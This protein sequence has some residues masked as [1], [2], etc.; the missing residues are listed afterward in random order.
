MKR[1]ANGEGTIKH[2]KDGRWEIQVVL[3]DGS[4][5]SLFGKTQ[6]EALDELGALR[7]SQE[8]GISHPN[9][10]KKV[11]TYLMTWI[12]YEQ[13]ARVH[14]DSIAKLPLAKLGPQHIE[15]LYADRLKAGSA[16]MTVRHLHALLHK[17][18]DQ[19]EKW[20]LVA[21]NA[22]ALVSPPTAAHQEMKTL[23]EAQS[24]TFLEAVAGER[25]EALHVLA[26]S[27]GMR[28]GEILALRWSD[29][30][31]DRASAQIQR[32]IQFVTG[33]YIFTPPKTAKSRRKVELTQTA[34]AALRRQR[35]R[36]IAE[37]LASAGGWAEQDLVF[38]DEAGGPTSP[39]RVRW[40]FQRVLKDAGLPRIRFHDLRHTAATL[41]LGRGVHPK[42][43]S[44]ML[45]HSTIAITLDLYS[46]VTPTMQREAAAVL[47][48]VLGSGA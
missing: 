13:L 6:R 11:G 4:R 33:R 25:F 23:S 21:R 27:T 48:S 35:V 19:A 30:D 34:I 10:R 29:L 24:R 12:R 41:L 7:K 17:A 9:D 28:Q 18:F 26:V 45:G 15:R 37:R 22:V 2:R 44:E 3:P 31:L 20:G 16:P 14:T 46:H 1:R 42:I 47:D 5:Q 39:D 43:V 8:K 40:A 38:A 32:S 36:Q